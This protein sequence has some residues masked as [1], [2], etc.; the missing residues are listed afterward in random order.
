MAEET[1]TTIER[2]EYLSDIVE[3]QR[4]E[5]TRLLRENKRVNERLDQMVNLQEREQVLRQQMQETL[6]RLTAEKLAISGSTTP[7]PDALDERIRHAERR[8]DALKQTVGLLIN[9]IEERPR[10]PG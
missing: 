1:G 5:L 4:T 7:S 9:L 6:D 8:Y 2:A 3:L 10:L